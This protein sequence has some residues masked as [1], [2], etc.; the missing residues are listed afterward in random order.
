MR[1]F[2]KQAVCRITAGVHHVVT[3]TA[4]IIAIALSGSAAA[5]TTEVVFQSAPIEPLIINNDRGGLLRVR[6]AEIAALRD[7]DRPVEIRGRVCYSTC[8]LFLGLPNTCVLPTTTFGFHGPS[9][10]GFPL[11]ADTF[12]TASRIIATHYPPALR[13]WY[14]E[15]GRYRINGLYRI[16]GENI[17]SLGVRAC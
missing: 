17:I 6:I 5:Q 1:V 11:D 4:V 9:N 15:T 12:N 16:S 10:Y 13:Q 3:R 14:L 8:T 2:I 7:E